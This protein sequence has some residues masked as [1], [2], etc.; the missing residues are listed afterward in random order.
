MRVIIENSVPK[1]ILEYYQNVMKKYQNTYS[2]ENLIDNVNKVENETYKVG[3]ELRKLN[4][5]ATVIIS[6]WRG[7]DVDYSKDTGWYF[8]Y[9]IE[10]DVVHIY[11]AVN[12][13]NMSDDAFFS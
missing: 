4:A 6:R 2:I 13:R 5:N 11:D 3:S 1:R 8:A 10:G 9:K 7:Y 12:H